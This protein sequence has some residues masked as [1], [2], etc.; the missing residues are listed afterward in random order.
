MRR[1][2]WVWPPLRIWVLFLFSMALAATAYQTTR[3][4]LRFVS[5][6]LQPDEERVV[7]AALNAWDELTD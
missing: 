6:N 7:L 4:G 2:F 1:P 5:R 3:E